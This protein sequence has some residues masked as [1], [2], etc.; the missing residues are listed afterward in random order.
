MGLKSKSRATR[1]GG[2]GLALL[3]MAVSAT[4]AGQPPAQKAA[5]Q[6]MF[7]QAKDLMKAGDYA[8][9]CKRFEESQRLDAAMG[10]QYRMANCY[11]KSG[12]LASAWSMYL[13]VAEA[14]RA[15]KLTER[16]AFARGRATALKP[17]IASMTISV[18]D[19]MSAV[20]GLHIERDGVS[21]GPGQWNAAVTVDDG[22]HLIT[23]T[24]PGK[25]HWESKI[26]VSALSRSVNVSVPLLADDPRESS[27]DSRAPDQAPPPPRSK[28]PAIALGAVA[29]VALGVGGA[30]LGV[31]AGKKGDASTL[32]DGILGDK[33]GCVPGSGNLDSRCGELKSQLDSAYSLQNTGGVTMVV[34][35][36]AAIAA[37]TYLLWPAPK[38]TKEQP[39]PLTVTPVHGRAESGFVVSGSF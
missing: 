37:V 38:G 12:R 14:A 35:G 34:G 18:P 28:T 19:A 5:A 27:S 30:L 33:N 2:F 10:T 13:E 16:E 7:D 26:L 4:A 36:A 23:A 11:E 25:K 15:A 21:V 20:S 22:E 6:A 24:A 17:K 29:V 1:I 8:T 3:L 9:A 32:H 39:P 31:G